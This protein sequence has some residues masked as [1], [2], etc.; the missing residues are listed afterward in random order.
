MENTGNEIFNFVSEFL[1]GSAKNIVIVPHENPDG[2]AVGS[3][4]GL[5]EILKNSGQNVCIISPNDY[6]DFLKWFSSEIEIFVFEREKKKAK[7]Y[8]K[9]A[10]LLICVDFN[11]AKRAAKMEREILGFSNLKL[12]IDH[13]PYPLNFCDYT[14]SEPKYSSTAELI[15]DFVG[16]IGFEKYLNHNSAEALYTGILTDTGSFSHNTARPNMFRVVSEL[17]KFGINTDKIQSNIYHNFSSD[18]MKLLGYCLNEKMEIFP[19]LR[20]AVISITKAE[21]E[22]FSFKPGDTEGFVNYPLSI[23]NIVFSALFIEKEGF[24]KA[25]FRSKGNFPANEFSSTHFNGG[26]HLNAA[27]GESKDDFNKTIELFK[28]LLPRY[29]H[30]LLET[31]I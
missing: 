25:S 2:D 30:Q 15:F 11:D 12:L 22:K 19:E 6:P 8:L 24:V 17:M 5:A 13:H 27:G 10:D 21:L 3:S 4:I 23:N 20:S 18:R 28:Q 7:E 9:K 1:A 29:K 16:K 14:V 26:G 31:K